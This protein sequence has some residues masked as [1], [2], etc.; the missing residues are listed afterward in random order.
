M[1]VI[2]K[3]APVVTASDVVRF[4]KFV[5]RRGDNECW[6]WI[7][8]TQFGYGRFKFHKDGKSDRRGSHVISYYLETKV[9]P[10]GKCVCHSCDNPSCCNPK[11]LWAGTDDDNQ[12]DSAKKN[13]TA[14]GY[15]RGFYLKHPDR[16]VR[17][18]NIKS[19]KLT[20]Q[21]VLSIRKIYSAGGRS[22][23][24]IADEFG[25]DQTIISDVVRR[26]TWKHV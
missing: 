2:V 1:A 25:V 22:Q 17:G 9:W 18:E 8:G 5:D 3:P 19:S 24:S 10:I 23:Q 21:Q 14:N 20:E 11:H 15:T 6:P 26:V 7:G 13:R 16:V 4:W 12:K